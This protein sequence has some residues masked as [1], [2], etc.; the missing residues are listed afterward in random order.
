MQP[1]IFVFKP[2]YRLMAYW[3]VILICK[4]LHHF[5]PDRISLS[6]QLLDKEDEAYIHYEVDMFGY[7]LNISNYEMDCHEIWYRHSCHSQDEL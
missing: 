2:Q 3:M 7:E 4:L 5:G 6:L 1:E